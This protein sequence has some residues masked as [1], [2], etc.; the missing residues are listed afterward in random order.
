MRNAEYGCVVLAVSVVFA[1]V[2]GGCDLSKPKTFTPPE[3]GES[4]W[5]VPLKELLRSGSYPAG[6]ALVHVFDR[7]TFERVDVGDLSP[8]KG[9]Y[10]LGAVRDGTVYWED[11]FDPEAERLWLMPWTPAKRPAAKIAT[12]GLRG[13]VSADGRVDGSDAIFLFAWLAGAIQFPSFEE[14]LG[15]IDDDGDTDWNDLA[16]LGAYVFADPRPQTNPHGIG[17]SLAPPPA[18]DPLDIELVFLDGGVLN[19][20]ARDQIEQ[21]AERWEKII[22]QGMEDYTFPYPLTFL[23]YWR[24]SV[25]VRGKIDD[26]RIYVGVSHEPNVR[27]L[28]WAN[29]PSSAWRRDSHLPVLGTVTFNS[30]KL[31]YI[32]RRDGFKP[33]A[34]HEIAHCLGFAYEY[35]KPSRLNLV[36]VRSP[37][38]DPHFTGPRALAAFDRLGGNTYGGHKVPLERFNVSHW[39][40][41]IFQNEVMGP[42]AGID[43]SLSEITIA[44][45]ED[46]GYEV[47]YS[48][49]D[50]Y[51]LPRAR[52]KPVAGHEH[53]ESWC[54]VLHPIG[55]VP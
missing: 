29:F 49:A 22:T 31:D 3:E 52:A 42:H 41:S 18:D 20:R 14:E 48:Y 7:S 1:M 53:D 33:I 37:V 23:T 54:E 38:G 13:D 28:A 32:T 9:R 26:I 35:W 11:N 36:R 8:E 44:A 39:R 46:M 17:L 40:E 24:Q 25:T 16:L 47:D 51:R 43:E 30:A 19:D 45:F 6:G 2:L 4:G 34:L 21:A 27:T 12:A 55:S 15:D 5:M 50:D 10:V